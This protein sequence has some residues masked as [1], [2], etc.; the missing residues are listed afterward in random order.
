MLVTD[1]PFRSGVKMLFNFFV[2]IAKIQRGPIMSFNTFIGI[3]LTLHVADQSA[4][5][6]MFR[7][8]DYFGKWHNPSLRMIG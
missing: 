6:G 5:G 2:W 1:D 7:Y 8:P 3:W 4:T